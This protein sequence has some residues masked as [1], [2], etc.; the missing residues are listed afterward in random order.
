MG[1][2]TAI[3][4]QIVGLE[5]FSAHADQGELLPWLG[6][7]G[8]KPRLY[9]VHAEPASAARFAAVVEKELGFPATVATPGMSVA[10]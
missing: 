6:T 2:R 7:L 4:A 9:V 10:L 8:T 3:L 1:W 5:G